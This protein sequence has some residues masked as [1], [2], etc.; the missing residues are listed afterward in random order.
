MTNCS[1]YATAMNDE[2][3]GELA[4][5]WT[6][7]THTVSGEECGAKPRPPYS[8]MHELSSRSLVQPELPIQSFVGIAHPRDVGDAVLIEPAIGFFRRRHVH[9]RDLRSPRF[10]GGALAGDVS[11]RFATKRS[12]EMT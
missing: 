4:P 6:S 12:P 8:R 7:R 2:D 11:Q 9:E 3:P 10:D 5:V 1:Q